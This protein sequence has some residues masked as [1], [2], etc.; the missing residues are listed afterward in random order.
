MKKASPELT[1]MTIIALKSMQRDGE[2]PLL[3]KVLINKFIMV[4]HSQKGAEALA[5]A[6]IASWLPPTK[7]EEN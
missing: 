6:R 4:G 2:L 3:R 5:D 7:A 1:A